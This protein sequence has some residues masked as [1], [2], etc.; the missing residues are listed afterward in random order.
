[1]RRGRH[2]SRP[3]SPATQPPTQAT[4]VPEEEPREIVRTSAA[5]CSADF[6]DTAARGATTRAA[7]R[8]GCTKAPSRRPVAAV[9]TAAREAVGLSAAAAEVTNAMVKGG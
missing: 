5:A 1:M 4:T 7:V 8:R 9:D 6:I 3:T 2:D